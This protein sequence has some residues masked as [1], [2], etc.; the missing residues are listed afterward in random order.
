M[1][2]KE[3]RIH[4]DKYLKDFQ[5]ELEQFLNEWKCWHDTKNDKKLND[6]ILTSFN[7][8][9]KRIKTLTYFPEYELP[10]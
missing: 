6:L 8:T 7:D 5:I 2:S 9:Y 3:Y 4:K 10:E 1:N